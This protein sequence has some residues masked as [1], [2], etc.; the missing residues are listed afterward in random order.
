MKADAPPVTAAPAARRLPMWAA[1]TIGI[2]CVVIAWF[3][4]LVTP[5]ADTAQAPFVVSA[6][7]GESATGRNIEVTVTDVRRAEHV[8]AGGWSAEGNWVVVDVEAASVL[9][10]VQLNRAVLVVDGTQFSASERPDSIRQASLTAGIPL[11]GSLAFELPEGLDAG[12]ASLEIA[13]APRGDTRLDSMIVLPFELAEVAEVGDT[14]LLA[15]EW[16]NL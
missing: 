2:G 10:E 11:S 13:L 8:A 15:T 9:S 14:E 4:A 3:V 12:D 6:A 16:T 5:D 1:W 7:V